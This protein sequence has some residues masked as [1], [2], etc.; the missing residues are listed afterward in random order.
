M[1]RVN[2]LYNP[3]GNI[4]IKLKLILLMFPNK[5]LND[6]IIVQRLKLEIFLVP[7]ESETTDKSVC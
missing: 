2:R 6:K 3:R 7:T 1:N 4:K 5:F